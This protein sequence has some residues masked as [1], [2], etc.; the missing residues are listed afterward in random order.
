MQKLILLAAALLAAPADAATRSYIV[1]DYDSIRL[2]APFDVTVQTRRSASA[3]GEGDAETLSRVELSVSS[4]ILVIRL[5]APMF[6][7]RRDKSSGPVRL[8]LGAPS[9]RRIHV[10]GAGSL[11]A[12]GVDRLKAEILV[13][14]SGALAVS[15]IDSDQLDLVQNGA[16]AVTLAGK[17]KTVGLQLVGSGTVDAKALTTSD[18]SLVVE[19]TGSVQTIA[20]RSAKI[21]VSGAGS[22]AVSGKAACI[23]THSGGG[24]VTC[25][26]RSY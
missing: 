8:S 6:E 4:R 24:A 21:V 18:L 20:E 7:A 13:S 11:R 5:R 2:E 17:A 23:V 1:T 3:R 14:G 12:D 15:G 22:A 26:G 10:T 9:L 25:G 16:G 19:G